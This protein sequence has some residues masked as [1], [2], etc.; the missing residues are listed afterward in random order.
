M[1]DITKSIALELSK[2]NNLLKRNWM[3]S[4]MKAELT[5]VTGKNGWI[6]GYI[7]SNP[8]REIFQRDIEEEFSIRRS[9]VSSMIQ[10]MEK[11]GF[12][13]RQSVGFDARLKKL[14]LTP[15]A[16]D[17]YSRMKASFRDCEH[18][19]RSGISDEELDV[20][21]SVLQKIQENAEKGE[22]NQ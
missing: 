5:D 18:I 12:V 9:T 4:D 15:K 2:T 13:E 7:A 14:T 11:K 19:L 1:E 8:D 6:I 20:F 17:M 16:Q 22:V 3:K 10:L 21:F